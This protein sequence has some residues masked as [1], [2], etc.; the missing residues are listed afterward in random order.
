MH[1]E[2]TQ[3]KR[4]SSDSNETGPVCLH[5]NTG[6]KYTGKAHLDGGRRKHNLKK[7]RRSGILPT[8]ILPRKRVHAAEEKK[9][10][11]QKGKK[12]SIV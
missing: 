9:K 5:T 1:T 4:S 3:E 6:K 8:N 2:T 7:G 12:T 10:H 11:P